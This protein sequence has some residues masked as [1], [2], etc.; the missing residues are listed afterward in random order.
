MFK[1]RTKNTKTFFYFILYVFF[2][3]ILSALLQQEMKENLN[4]G[5]IQNKVIVECT[6]FLLNFAFIKT[7]I[8][9]RKN[10]EKIH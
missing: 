9:K 7:F 8:F 3:C 10:N 1:D 2:M 4:F 5:I 6:L